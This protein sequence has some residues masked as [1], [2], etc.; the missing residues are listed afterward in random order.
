MDYVKQQL[1]TAVAIGRVT[2]RDVLDA[3]YEPDSP[4]RKLRETERR[5]LSDPLRKKPNEHAGPTT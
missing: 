5:S 1:V 3:K 4:T 2:L